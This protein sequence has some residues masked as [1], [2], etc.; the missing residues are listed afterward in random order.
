MTQLTDVA[1]DTSRFSTE[2]RR[3]WIFAFATVA[4]GVGL[5]LWNLGSYG[6]TYDET[7]TGAATN[8]SIPQIIER[9]WNIDVHPP[10]AYLTVGL[11][12]PDGSEFWLRVPSVLASIGTLVALGVWLRDRGRVAPIAVALASVSTFLVLHGREARAYAFLALAGVL[13]AWTCERWLR[14]P[15]RRDTWVVF[16]LALAVLFTHYSALVF[17]VCLALL[18]GLRRDRS[19]WEFRAA[20]AV[21]LML[22]AVLW[23]PAFLHQSGSGDTDT[24]PLVSLSWVEFTLDGL[25]TYQSVPRF[26]IPALL[27]G[28][29]LAMGRDRILQRVA[30]LGFV[31]PTCALIVLGV[32]AHLFIPR[33]MALGVWM[34]IVGMAFLADWLGRRL[35]PIGAVGLVALG[36]VLMLPSTIDQVSSGRNLEAIAVVDREAGPGD[37]VAIAPEHLGNELNWAFTIKRNWSEVVLREDGFAEVFDPES[38]SGR[39]WLLSFAAEGPPPPP[40]GVPRCAEDRRVGGTW[41]TCIVSD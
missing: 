34:P 23:G 8:L 17:L 11:L 26:L 4:L 33:T 24:F 16:V 22:W 3:W 35:G 40:D 41:V 29:F 7:W 1:P 20:I 19:A 14:R 2:L 12:V 18:P 36:F 21:P 27:I 13:L 10:L 39:T 30:L 15:S 9:T 31:V 25:F 32:K 38:S 37:R 6:L 28:G 5:R